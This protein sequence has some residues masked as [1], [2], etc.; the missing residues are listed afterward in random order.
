[1]I[2]GDII[3]IIGSGRAA[4]RHCINLAEKGRA[5]IEPKL[6]GIERYT[7]MDGTFIEINMDKLE[8]LCA[9]AKLELK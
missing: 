7:F 3:K 8:I 9:G 5:T 2:S 6:G 4:V 1:M